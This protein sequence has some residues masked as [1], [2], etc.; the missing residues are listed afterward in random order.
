M[1]NS[2]ITIEHTTKLG[3]IVSLTWNE[4]TGGV[5]VVVRYW[6]S[7]AK[8]G[9]MD[10]AVKRISESASSYVDAIAASPNISKEEAARAVG[11]ILGALCMWRERVF[12]GKT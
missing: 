7:I 3:D 9:S 8:F 5:S 2:Q 1:T 12:G 10:E 11:S 6:S 4:E